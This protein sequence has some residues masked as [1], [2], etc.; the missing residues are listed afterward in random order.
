MACIFLFL[1]NRGISLSVTYRLDDNLLS[2]GHWGTF[3]RG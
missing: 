3:P 2:N 1:V